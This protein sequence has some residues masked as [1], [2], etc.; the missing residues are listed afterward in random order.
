MKRIAIV[1]GAGAL[2]TATALAL[3]PFSASAAGT[4]ASVTKLK[5]PSSVGNGQAAVFIAPVVSSTKGSGRPTGTVTFTITGSDASTVDCTAGDVVTLHK[6]DRAVCNV[7]AGL[8][9]PSASPY[10]VSAVYSGDDTFAGSNASGSEPV[11]ATNTTITVSY[12]AKPASKQAT[13]FTA[14]VTGHGGTPTGTVTFVVAAPGHPS[15]ARCSPGGRTQPVGPDASTP[16]NNVAVCNLRPGWLTV[17]KATK[18]NPHPTS[19]WTVVA[20]YNGD[21]NF[22]ASSKTMS[23]TASS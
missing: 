18:S 11:T 4:T 6:R 22:R 23:G 3:S 21:A 20:T 9:S 15:K 16:P 10:A 19:T 13:V 7:A 17:R 14:T 8:L 1:A 12:D 5:M 2:A